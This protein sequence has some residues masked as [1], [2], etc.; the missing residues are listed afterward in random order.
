MSE[1]QKLVLVFEELC[2]N[3]EITHL[4]EMQT[5]DLYRYLILRKV[6][7]LYDK[8]EKSL[9]EIQEIGID[10]KNMPF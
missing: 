5:I 6:T 4:S 10:D 7:E 3:P 8:K 9:K 2:N 1:L